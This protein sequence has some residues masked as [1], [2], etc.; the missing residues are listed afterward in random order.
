[1]SRQQPFSTQ[2]PTLFFLFTLSVMVGCG[3]EGG[4]GNTPT[5]VD[6]PKATSIGL[7]VSA[8]VL[9]AIGATQQLAASVKDQNGGTMSGTS[10]QWSSS[11]PLVAT[12]SSSG[13]VKAAGVGTATISAVAGTVSAT[14]SVSVTQAVSSVAISAPAE[15][16]HEIGATLQFVAEVRDANGNAIP[17]APVLWTSSDALRTV[18]AESVGP[19]VVE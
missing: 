5:Q 19:E 12:V 2:L 3:S 11:D 4:S 13:S 18:F 10:V 14:A 16:L 6:A 8:V 17:N 1:M 7:N 15:I 9:E